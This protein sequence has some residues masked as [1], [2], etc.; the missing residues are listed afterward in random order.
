MLAEREEEV[1]ADAIMRT[2]SS[3]RDHRTRMMRLFPN[4]PTWALDLS[5]LHGCRTLLLPRDGD[6]VGLSVS[7]RDVGGRTRSCVDARAASLCVVDH[8]ES[9]NSSRSEFGSAAYQFG[10]C[11]ATNASRDWDS[12][13]GGGHARHRLDAIAKRNRQPLY[14]GA[15]STNEDLSHRNI[16]FHLSYYSL[17]PDALNPGI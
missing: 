10:T 17:P 11:R 4:H 5:V 3:L 2:A 7:V 1:D 14:T 6:N 15:A 8:I 16:L 9:Q 13:S 12:Q